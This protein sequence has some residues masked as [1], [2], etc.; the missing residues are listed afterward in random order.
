MFKS[1]ILTCLLCLYSIGSFTQE[2]LFKIKALF[3]YQLAKNIQWQE[4][5]N[6]N[7]FKIGVY[8]N[9]SFYNLLNASLSNK[10]IKNSDIKVYYIESNKNSETESF[11]L[12]WIDNWNK[13]L[14]KNCLIITET[15]TGHISFLMKDNKL[16]Y[17]LNKDLLEKS[18]LKPS[19]EIIALSYK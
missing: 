16:R 15:N 5:S 12:I 13:P 11:D 4:Y 18:N 17:T 10:K 3:I 2:S 9:K 1:F 7:L 8:D 19:T 6:T 14:L